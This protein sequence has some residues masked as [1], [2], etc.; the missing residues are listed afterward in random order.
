MDALHVTEP[1][2]GSERPAGVPATSVG[3]RI[4]GAGLPM[5]SDSARPGT[6]RVLLAGGE[7]LMRAS[8]TAVLGTGTG[9][10]V[11]GEAAT[12]DEA[13]A[14]ARRT[15]PDVVLIDGADGL[16]VLTTT[17]RLLADP[18]LAGTQV[19]MFGRFER[20]EDVL[21][22][23]RIGVSGLVDRDVPPYE[24]VQA[25]RMA[26]RGA[27]FVLLSTRRRLLG[28]VEPS[29]VGRERLASIT[30]REREVV[31]LVARGLTDT[32][33]AER[34]AISPST[35][36]THLTRAMWKLHAPSR[37]AIVAIA[38]EAGFIIDVEEK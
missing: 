13:I 33:I 31:A 4:L 1:P 27:A 8:V 34:L 16:H 21:A 20:E 24:L 5:R 30:D 7:P 14:V 22:A 9:T 32:E 28:H 3:R 17:R 25:V 2:V 12:D 10:A 37:A 26:A 15:R 23:L 36:K 11:V 35:A 19:L 29:R 6:I 38:R 18:E